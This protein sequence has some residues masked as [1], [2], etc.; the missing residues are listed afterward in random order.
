MREAKVLNETWHSM[1]PRTDLGNLLCGSISVAY[2]AE[3]G[4]KFLGV[5]IFSQPIVRSLCD[6]R[7]IELR[8]LALGPDAPKNSASRM[9][10]VTARL[11]KRKYRWINKI[12]SYQAVDVHA[13]T[14]YRAAGWSPVGK[15]VPAR[16]QRMKGSKQ[17]ATGPLQTHSRKLRWE[18]IIGT[19][20]Y[21][22]EE[23]ETTERIRNL[24]LTSNGKNA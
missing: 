15:V 10:A 21:V 24:L 5:A 11:V 2:A 6:G 19:D 12:V 1:L 14:I 18:K 16:P 8:R 4:G 13:G 17:R 23:G 7:T 3:Y 9:M 20:A 22:P